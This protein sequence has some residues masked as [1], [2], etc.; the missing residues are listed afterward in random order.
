MRTLIS[1]LLTLLVILGVGYLLVTNSPPAPIIDATPPPLEIINEP[2]PLIIMEE[3][4]AALATDE[5]IQ[6]D[7][8]HFVD[9]LK[10]PQNIPVIISDSQGGFVRHDSEII[11]IRNSEP[12]DT[13]DTAERDPTTLRIQNII[14]DP[15]LHSDDMFYLHHVTERDQQGLWGI[16]QHGLV[17]K[18]RAGL[19]LEGISHTRDTL[20]VIIPADADEQLTNGLSSFLGK[21]LS[22]KVHSSYIYNLE[23]KQLGHNPNIIQAG[24]QLVLIKFSP[25]ELKSVYQFFAQQRQQAVQTY[26]I[27][28]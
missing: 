8:E 3:S 4:T 17:E 19:S 14:Q 11:L 22:Q 20:Q 24:Q 9:I 1:L 12:N 26:G 18:F 6:Q 27:P 23:T 7:A 13:D 15:S 5:L 2:P 25:D 21:L 10:K 28:D 16:I